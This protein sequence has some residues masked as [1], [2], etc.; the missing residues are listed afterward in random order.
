MR[1]KFAQRAVNQRNVFGRSN[2]S[3]GEPAARL[4]PVVVGCFMLICGVLVATGVADPA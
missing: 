2:A 1:K 4:G 3:S